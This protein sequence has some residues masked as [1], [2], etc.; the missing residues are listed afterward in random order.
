LVAVIDAQL[1]SKTS[2]EEN[3]KKSRWWK[4]FKKVSKDM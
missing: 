4:G 3:L 1:K 2:T